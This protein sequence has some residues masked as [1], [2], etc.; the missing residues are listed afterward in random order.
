MEVVFFFCML[1]YAYFIILIL[2][3]LDNKLKGIFTWINLDI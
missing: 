1:L 3:V 2:L